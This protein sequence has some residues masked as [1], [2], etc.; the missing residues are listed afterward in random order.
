MSKVGQHIEYESLWHPSIVHVVFILISPIVSRLV[1]VST[2]C[3]TEFNRHEGAYLRRQ[4]CQ[5]LTLESTETE[6]SGPL[7]EFLSMTCPTE[8][9]AVPV[10]VSITVSLCECP[11]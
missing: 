2:L 9:P 10:V 8:V 11:E 1:I 4:V 6:V 7:I 5:Y 3:L